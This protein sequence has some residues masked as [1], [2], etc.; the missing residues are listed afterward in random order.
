MNDSALLIWLY[1]D[2]DEII[3]FDGY[4]ESYGRYNERG[5]SIETCID[6][7]RSFSDDCG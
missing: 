4:D 5:Q 7:G 1:A 2:I 3:D 6:Y